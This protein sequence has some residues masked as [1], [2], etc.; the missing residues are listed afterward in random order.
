MERGEIKRLKSIGF[1]FLNLE[2]L[3]WVIR[4][5]LFVGVAYLVFF[6]DTKTVTNF[7]R[8]DR[9][10]DSIVILDYKIIEH[11]KTDSIIKVIRN[12]EIKRLDSIPDDSL[13]AY[14]IRSINSIR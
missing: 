9:S 3:K 14:I 4:V 13:R 6:K 8:Q 2:S 10:H 5:M 1:S 7:V 12:E 11:R